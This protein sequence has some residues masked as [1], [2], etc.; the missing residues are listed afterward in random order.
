[1][2][3]RELI[4]LVTVSKDTTLKVWSLNVAEKTLTSIRTEI[5]HE[6]DINCAQSHLMVV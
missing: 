6:K 5:A 3:C 4:Q 2:G 1:M